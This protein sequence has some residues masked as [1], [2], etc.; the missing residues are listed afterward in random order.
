MEA[1]TEKLYKIAY[2]L[3]LAFSLRGELGKSG[4]M[5]YDV[6]LKRDA[7]NFYRQSYKSSDHE[8]YLMRQ[9]I[10]KLLK[11]GII[12]PSPCSYVQFCSPA[13][14]V[15]KSDKSARLVADY[16]L[17]NKNCTIDHFSF[18]RLDEILT[19]IDKMSASVYASFDLAYSFF[20]IPLT[21]ENK[22]LTTF[23]TEPHKFYNYLRLPQGL[24]NSPAALA[25]LISNVFGHLDFLICY[26]DDIALLSTSK[27]D[28][29]ENLEKFLKCVIR[30]NL[31]LSLRKSVLMDNELTFLGHKIKDRSISPT[32]KHISAIKTLKS[33]ND[34]S[35]LKIILGSLNW[36]KKCI[37]SYSS[38]TRIFYELL[39]KN[40]EF[41]WTEQHEAAFQE[42]KNYLISNHVLKLPIGAG[43]YSL[44]CDGSRQGL[45]LL[46]L[47]QLMAP[48]M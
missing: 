32:E 46:S 16:H 11:L 28:H 17:L 30:D 35:S 43:K 12:E 41:H 33:P 6:R 20:Q 5:V 8:R 29:F 24:Y 48:H 38:R 25:K 14:L 34:K 40:V 23:T 13:L 44:F 27:A 3:R 15:A 47:K 36:L 7:D 45:E 9:E 10:A 2:N 21:P 18:P 4:S 39:S 22:G 37:E 31:K 1:E 26:A 42:I 19:K